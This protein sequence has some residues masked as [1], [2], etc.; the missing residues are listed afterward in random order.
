MAPEIVMHLPEGILPLSQAVAMTAVAAPLVAWSMMGLRRDLMEA[1]PRQRALFGFGAALLFALTL[2]PLPIPPL[3]FSLHLCAAPLLGLLLGLRPVIALTTF[4]LIAQLLFAAHGG[5]STLGANIITLGVIG[6]TAAIGLF[7][8]VP[9]TRR[10][11]LSAGICCGLA[12]LAVYLSTIVILIVAFEITASTQSYMSTLLMGLAALVVPLVI[13][14]GALSAALYRAISERMDTKEWP[15]NKS[16]KT[17]GTAA[18]GLLI[19]L[20]YP[21]NA[22]AH[23]DH[24]HHGDR[25]HGHHHEDLEGFDHLIYEG[26]A[27]EAGVEVH[28]LDLLGSTLSEPIYFLVLFGSGCLFGWS[29]AR[30]S[31][32]QSVD[33]GKVRS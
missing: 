28:H 4:S 15:V 18:M 19:A 10:G 23:S 29:W 26:A 20:I 3:G 25:D 5:F 2:F 21:R 7:K 13:A 1:K 24:D 32:N 14:E 33:E 27:E 31:Q 30:L 22:T 16:S 8:C 6:P 17:L 11:P 9:K 12:S